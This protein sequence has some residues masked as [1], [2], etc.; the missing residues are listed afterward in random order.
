MHAAIVIIYF[1]HIT[2]LVYTV[3]GETRRYFL[4][5][6]CTTVQKHIG[7]PGFFHD[8]MFA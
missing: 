6:E 1:S 5:Y 4:K 2:T 8:I 7:L 3:S